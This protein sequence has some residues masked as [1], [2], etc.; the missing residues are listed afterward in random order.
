M[1]VYF[2]S[3]TSPLYLHDIHRIPTQ[4]LRKL[5]FLSSLQKEHALHIYLMPWSLIFL[6]VLLHPN[7]L[8]FSA[9]AMYLH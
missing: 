4:T 3:S 5:H 2:H 9:R 7:R 8:I 1:G 6:P